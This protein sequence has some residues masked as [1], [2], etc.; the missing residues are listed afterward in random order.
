M[1]VRRALHSP[2]RIVGEHLQSLL[3]RGGGRIKAL[4]LG[5]VCLSVTHCGFQPRSAA[6]LPQPLRSIALHSHDPYGPLARALHTQ[7]RRHGF[8]LVEHS[9]HP[10][11][12]LHLLNASEERTLRSLFS[13]GRGAQYQLIYRV[14]A[15][16]HW[17]N[18]PA[19]TLS[20]TRTT[21]SNSVQRIPLATA[22]AQ[23]FFDNPQAALAKSVEQEIVQQQLCQQAADQLTLQLL[24]LLSEKVDA[25][26]LTGHA[27]PDS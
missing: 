5:V 21:P 23:S 26:P 25:A 7:L 4:L 6:Q 10:S 20:T 8:I 19:K 18:P 17:S 14:T 24:L 3:R 12:Q 16:L 11:L 2:K 1:S 27:T 9:D 22:V 15:Q 13:D